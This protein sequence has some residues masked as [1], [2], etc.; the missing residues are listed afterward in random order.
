MSL[1]EFKSSISC[2]LMEFMKF[3]KK[4]YAV[5]TC[6]IYLVHMKSF[7]QYLYEH[8]FGGE[9]IPEDMVD[10]WIAS[11]HGL[12]DF[13]IGGYV[14]TLRRFLRFREG[15]GMGGYIP[16]TR[17]K[18]YDYTPYIFSDEE[19]TNICNIADNYEVRCHNRLPYIQFELP[20]V[21]RILCGCGTRLG[22]T[23]AIKMADVDLDRH[24]LTLRTTKWNKERLM[25][26]HHQL[27]DILEQYC[28]AMGLIGNPDAY[29]FP[30]HSF[31]DH[32]EQYD[33]RN[34][35]NL[36]LRLAGISMEGRS[37]QERGPCMHCLRHRFVFKSFQQ[38]EAAGI[39]VDDAVPILSVYLGHYDLTETEKYMKFSA[40]LF[41]NEMEKFESFSESFFL[42]TK[43]D[44]L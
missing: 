31:S 5:Q 42:D 41:P 12:R 2:E 23:I 21:I 24:I 25:P 17:K 19:I 20:M 9:Y 37:F 16:P 15:F 27:G 43:E 33:M 22:E 35:F 32:L 30:R 28:R 3:C 29:L 14:N 4:S 8:G 26:M 34:R 7:D 1:C 6:R 13:T 39:R 36:I 44:G 40:Q 11:L 18:T 38:L 10:G